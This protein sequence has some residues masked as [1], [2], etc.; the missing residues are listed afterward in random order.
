M[1]EVAGYWY[2]VAIDEAAH[3]L[4][5]FTAYRFVNFMHHS[6]LPFHLRAGFPPSPT[7]DIKTSA[8]PAM[9][10]ISLTYKVITGTLP[11]LIAVGVGAVSILAIDRALRLS[12]ANTHIAGK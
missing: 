12:S 4:D 11:G 3:R 7:H 8:A 2:N 9:Q 1:F 6:K 5:Y 10:R